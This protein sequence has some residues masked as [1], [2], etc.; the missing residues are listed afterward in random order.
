MTQTPSPGRKLRNLL[1]IGENIV[2]PGAHDPL[3]ARVLQRMGFKAL[4]CAGWMTA[5]HLVT[6]EP[7]L[8]MTEQVDVAR[9]V[10]QAVDIPIFSDAGTGYGEPIHVMRAV[11]EFERAGVAMIHIEDQHFPKRASYHRGLEHVCDFDEFMRRLE[12]ALKARKDPDFM[13]FARSDAGHAVDG[14]WKEAAR[15]ARAA[16]ALGVDG[17]LPMTRTKDSMEKFRQE[18]PDNDM[19]LMTT[20]YFNG[21]PPAELRKLGFQM[22]AYPLATIIASI[23]GVMHLY[24]NVLNTGVATMDADLAKAVREEIEQAIGLPEFWEIERQTV[25]A[26]HAGFTGKTNAG[27]E[28]HRQK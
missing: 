18:Y 7:V 21:L 19:T 27:Y 22:Q 8:T 17:F 2:I 26:D 10:A 14:S 28:G 3:L 16:K 15:R 1:A 20:T 12:W 25:E 23:A 4:A 9:R 13:I 5:G 6:P 24:K 11:K